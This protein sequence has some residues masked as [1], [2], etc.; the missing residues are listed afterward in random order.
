MVKAIT[1][2]RFVFIKDHLLYVFKKPFKNSRLVTLPYRYE[3]SIVKFDASASFFQQIFD[4]C[5]VLS[6]M[7]AP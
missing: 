7:R 6:E 3:K 4:V 5:S 1:R 2:R